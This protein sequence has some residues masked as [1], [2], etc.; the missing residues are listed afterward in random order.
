MIVAADMPTATPFMLHIYAAMAEAEG[1]RSARAQSRPGRCQSSWRE[2]EQPRLLAGS[3]DQA[4]MAAEAK[5][6]KATAGATDLLPVIAEVRAA[7]V[8]TLSGTA[9]ALTARGVPTPSG[10]GAWSPALRSRQCCPG[11]GRG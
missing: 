10:R 4:R 3:R 6:A 8:A 1:L 7:G 5:S 9:K 2:A 11:A